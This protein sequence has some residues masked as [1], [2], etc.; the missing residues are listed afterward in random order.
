MFECFNRS[1]KESIQTNRLSDTAWDDAL[2]QFSYRTAHYRA[3]GGTPTDLML[4]RPLRTMLNVAVAAFLTNNTDCQ[5]HQ[6]A[7]RKSVTPL[8]PG[9]FVH[10][11]ANKCP[12]G[13]PMLSASIRVTSVIRPDK[14]QL[15]DGR[16]VNARRLFTS[17][18]RTDP[19]LPS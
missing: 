16:T 17:N 13:Q 5:R 8:P 7:C 18:K 19:A 3:T 4:L 6:I 9:A 2:L 14:Y 12:N 1:L 10:I 15:E 11:K